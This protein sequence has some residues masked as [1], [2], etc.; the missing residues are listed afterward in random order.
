MTDPAEINNGIEM[1]RGFTMNDGAWVV[2]NPPRRSH[3]I[4]KWCDGMARLVF[5]IPSTLQIFTY[6]EGDLIYEQAQSREAF[7]D[8]IKRNNKFYRRF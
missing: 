2:M 7:F 4:R 6:C 5:L 1:L 8:A 3:L